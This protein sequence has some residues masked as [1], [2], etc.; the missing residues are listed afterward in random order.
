MFRLLS[1]QV[2]QLNSDDFK[3]NVVKLILGTGL[4]QVLPIAV[5]PILTRMYSPEDFGIFAIYMAVAGILGVV[6]TGRYELSIVL[7]DND[8]EASGIFGVCLMI[9]LIV[10]IGSFFILLFFHDFFRELLSLPRASQILFL[11]P[12]SVFI[13]GLLQSLSYYNIRNKL[14]KDLSVSKVMLGSGTATSQT[15]GGMIP[16]ISG[17]GLSLGYLL[18]QIFS[19]IYLAVKSRNL[20]IRNQFEFHRLRALAKK[21]KKFPLLSAPGAL[22]DTFAA[23]IPVFL[24]NNSYSA[25]IAGQFSLALRIINVPLGLMGAAISQVFLQKVVALDN[26]KPQE[27]RSVVLNLAGMLA[28]IISPLVI[29]SYLFGEELFV[30]IFGPEWQIAGSFAVPISLVVS[31]RFIVSPLSSVLAIERNLKYAIFW[32]ASYFISTSLALV[33]ASQFSVHTFLIVFVLNELLM[34]LFYFCLILVGANSYSIT[35]AD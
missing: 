32:Q 16:S 14:F 25:S 33:Y 1:S 2:R 17:F 31:V 24:I 8:K 35:N 28:L 12:F 29:V 27:V 5:L 34:Y 9:T 26:T 22:L 10:S 6:A 23:Q 4:A 13:A 3:S 15:M 30:F 18:G 19:I 11:V 20:F 7:P 21:Y